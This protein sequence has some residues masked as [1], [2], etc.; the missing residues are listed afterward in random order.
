MK[1][2]IRALFTLFASFILSFSL[3]A[4]DW[5]EN[6]ENLIYSPRYFGPNGFPIP[7]LRDG[8][9]GN[10][11]EI[12]LRG[13]YHNYSGDKTHNLF[14]RIYLPIVKGRAAVEVSWNIYE[15]YKTTPETRDERFAA[16]TESPIGCHGDLIVSALFQLLKSEKW[17]DITASINLKTASG[18]RLCD[19]RYTDA[20]SYWFDANFGKDII[21][22]PE[23]NFSLRLQAMMGFYCWMT[24]DMVHRQNDAITYGGGFTAN[25][26]NF[27]LVSDLSGFYGYKD[28]GD[29]P[30]ALRNHLS[31]EYKKNIVSFR[32]SHGM[33]DRLYDSYS[34][35]YTRCF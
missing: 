2:S 5:R 15:K 9:V 18:N 10:R 19:A 14:A 20:A 7:E 33:K 12:E 34:L 35:G 16:E 28:N 31:Y 17:L 3:Q 24:N 27:S 1:L 13:I 8:Q 25:Y 29:R 11:Y 21:S 23:H 6:M 32:Y 4:Q 22:L 30:M 26:R